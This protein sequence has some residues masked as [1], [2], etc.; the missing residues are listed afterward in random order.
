M[1]IE[2]EAASFR[3]LHEDWLETLERIRGLHGFGEFL[4]SKK[5]T[6]LKQAAFGG[7]VVLLNAARS[8][9]D[10]LIVTPAGVQHVPLSAGFSHKDAVVVHN[11]ILSTT[12]AGSAPLSDGLQGFFDEL[13]QSALKT[14]DVTFSEQDRHLERKRIRPTVPLKPDD[15]F[16]RVLTILWN[17]V[18]KPVIRALE[19][20]AVSSFPA[21]LSHAS[22]FSFM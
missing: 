7:P 17:L 10:G 19:L 2:A 16:S 1:T 22:H 11:L 14:R 12:Y 15:V 6:L 21:T 3:R 9:C 5:F 13:L 4:R 20:N 18:A 8:S